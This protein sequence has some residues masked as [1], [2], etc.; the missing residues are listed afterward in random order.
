[1]NSVFIS[2]KKDFE[3][4]YNDK[5]KKLNGV[6]FE[7]EPENEKDLNTQKRLQFYKQKIKCVETHTKYFM[8]NDFGL[9]E[10]KLLYK[11]LNSKSLND[12]NILNNIE[13]TFSVLYSYITNVDEIFNKIKHH[14]LK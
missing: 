11:P 10:M 3:I 14:L 1:M 13:E 12:E 5:Y 2:D 4:I 9:Y 7:V 6:Y 8:P